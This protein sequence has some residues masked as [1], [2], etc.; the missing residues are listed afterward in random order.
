LDR[1]RSPKTPSKA[2]VLNHRQIQALNELVKAKLQ[3]VNSKI[4][5]AEYE[6]I[7]ANLRHEESVGQTS[8][9]DCFRNG[10]GRNRLRVLT[11]I[12]LQAWQQLTGINFIFYYGTTFFTQAGIDNPFIITIITNIVNVISTLPGIWAVDNLGRRKLLLIGA[13][14]MCIC[15]YIVAIVGV[16]T[17]GT[18]QSAQKSLIAFV[19]IYIFFF[20]ASW[21]PCAWVVTGE[22]Y[23]LG[24]RAKAMSMSTASNWLWNWGIGYATPYLVDAP[25]TSG[26]NITKTANL[27]SK[28][29]FIWGATCF[30][31]AVFTYFFIPEVKGLSLEQIDLLYR[32]SSM[33]NSA[34]Y[35]KKMKAE[36]ETFT[37]KALAEQE[38]G[39]DHGKAEKKQVIADTE[40]HDDVSSPA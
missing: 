31:C 16:T 35:N 1:P 34:A 13:A 27:K 7:E 14:G 37:S 15:E 10:P 19:C 28:V 26:P 21:G 3:T 6:E 25:T 11:G 23:P 22:L 2:I 38:L 17:P 9:L 29:F 39:L 40:H 33:M 20:A 32:E 36:N 30:S 8:Y 12:F 5:E 24:I 18:N 4:A